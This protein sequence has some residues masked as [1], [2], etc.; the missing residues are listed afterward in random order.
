MVFVYSKGY[1]TLS[2]WWSQVPE[3][4]KRFRKNLYL[5]FPVTRKSKI[6]FEMIV[7]FLD[8]QMFTGR[9]RG[10]RN[11]WSLGSKGL[12]YSHRYVICLVE[13]L[14]ITKLFVIGFQTYSVAILVI[15]SPCPL[16]STSVPSVPHPQPA[17]II[18]F[19]FCFPLLSPFSLWA[20]VYNTDG[21][22]GIPL[23]FLSALTPDPEWHGSVSSPGPTPALLHPQPTRGKLPVKNQFSCS[24]FLFSLFVLFVITLLRKGGCSTRNSALL[25]SHYCTRSHTA[26]QEHTRVNVN[27]H[28]EVTNQ[29]WEIFTSEFF[30]HIMIW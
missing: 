29:N 3:Q 26:L 25:L 27:Y 13:S 5:Y 4:N 8:W 12:V 2:F 9:G 1:G 18:F 14:W 22:S 16:P 19:P 15:P 30:R 6:W 28:R 21:A 24:S 11:I 10:G 17:T 23:Y 20:L 7:Q